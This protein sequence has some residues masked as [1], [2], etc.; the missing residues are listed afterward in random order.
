MRVAKTLLTAITILVLTCGSVANA[1]GVTLTVSDAEANTSLSNSV[2]IDI[3]VDDPSA[4]AGAAFTLTY[5]TQALKLIAVESDF[6]APFL[7]QFSELPGVGTPFVNPQ[8][9]KTYVPFTEDS[10]TVYIPVEEI[11]DGESYSQPLMI[12]TE[13]AT[14]ISI[15]AARLMTGEQSN[16]TLF[17]LTFDVSNAPA[18]AYDVSIVP[19]TINNAQAGYSASGEAI[20]MLI[21]AMVMS[22]DPNNPVIFPQIP[23][24][25]IQDGTIIVTETGE[26][27]IGDKPADA[28]VVEAGASSETFTAVGGDNTQYNW[29]ITDSNGQE[30]DTHTGNTYTFTAPS[31]GTF[32]GVYTVT[33]TDNQGVS[34]SFDVKVP[35]T[36]TPATLS[37]TEMKLDGSAN[38]Q[39]FTVTGADGDYTWEILSSENAM[40]AVADPDAYGTWDENSPVYT[41]NTNTF[42]PA[43]IDQ[44]QSFYI[45]VTVD[46]DTKLT[47][48]N[49]LNRRVAG[50]FTLVPV[51]TY[52]VI[53][54]DNLGVIDGTLLGAGDI[55]VKEVSTNQI[56]T[57]VSGN[58]EVRFLLPDANGT[59]QYKVVD[60]RTPSVYI[61][62]T[63]SAETKTVTITLEQEGLE[64]IYGLVEDTYSFPISGATVTAYQADDITVRYKATTAADGSYNISLP[65][66][67]QLN[68]WMVVASHPD[69]IPQ[70]QDSQAVGAVDFTGPLSLYTDTVIKNITFTIDGAVMRLD[71]TVSPA[72]TDLSEI[73]VDLID[74]TGTLGNLELTDN[75]DHSST[76]T[77]IYDTV[78]DF[79]VAIRADTSEDH[80]PNVG[81]RA[82]KTFAYA[83]NAILAAIS[84]IY[85]GENGGEASLE[86]N[87]QQVNVTVPAGGVVGDV[88]ITIEQF[89]NTEGSQN[90]HPYVYD[91]TAYNSTTGERLSDAEINYLEITLPLDLSVVNPGD[92]ENGRVVIYHAENFFALEANGGSVVP[93]SD[94]ISTDYVG[95]GQTGSVTFSVS[96]L[97]VFE[98]ASTNSGDSSTASSSRFSLPW[99]ACFI[100]T[101]SRSSARDLY[102]KVFNQLRSAYQRFAE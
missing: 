66:G 88:S 9:G 78:E 53:L 28:P 81:Y 62:K 94:I 6:F 36:V 77:V 39:T 1:F 99:D 33:A 84:Q 59:F 83:R 74:G 61:G 60:T 8:D 2:T 19:T 27:A 20:P 57:S 37:F 31:T 41:D 49:G 67:A 92:L 38:P 65:V 45:R 10:T 52:T 90:T 17:R 91:V 4:I 15:V 34:D 11:I 70:Q 63:V 46:N 75:I 98:I 69:Y 12:G 56:K 82:E 50:P 93:S 18:G 54:Q 29:T 96:H 5:N 73:E 44:W 26:F 58:G 47:A 25:E 35:M 24:G 40:N 102:I 22:P 42:N 13:T 30:T 87:G 85:I 7:D 76:V 16:H 72:I 89:E 68:G 55:T 79:T 95:D 100:A 48:T 86:A 97:S 71:M 101:A 80:Y 64:S 23:V 43:D 32:A 3:T 51:D 14:G 21:G